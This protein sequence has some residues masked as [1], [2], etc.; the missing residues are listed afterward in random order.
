M[1]GKIKKL[2]LFQIRLGK[3]FI[4][5]SFLELLTQRIPQKREMFLDEYGIEIPNV[6]IL[7]SD[8]L[9]E[10]EYEIRVSG[11]PVQRFSC[12]KSC[13][14]AFVTGKDTHKIKG[15]P[16]KDP[17]FGMDALWISD[18]KI[19]TAKNYGFHAYPHDTIVVTNLEEVIK[20][21][22]KAIITTQY[23]E[24]LLTEAEEENAALVRCIRSKYGNNVLFTVKGVLVSLL[25]ELVSIRD[26]ISILEVISDAASDDSIAT[27]AERTRHVLGHAIVL[28]VCNDGELNII[29][30][31]EETISYLLRHCD[32]EQYSW[33]FKADF[34]SKCSEIITEINNQNTQPAIIVPDEIRKSVWTLIN[35]HIPDITVIS[36]SEI[37]TAINKSQFLKIN[38]LAEISVEKNCMANEA[39]DNF[40]DEKVMK[41]ILQSDALITNKKNGIVV[42]LRYENESMKCP[43]VLLAQKDLKL[44]KLLTETKK[45]CDASCIG[46]PVLENKTLANGLFLDCTEDKPIDDK[47][48]KPVANVYALLNNRNK[49]VI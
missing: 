47:Y 25:E 28:Q 6:N 43:K 29:Q 21:N 44:V 7:E 20:K 38:A 32:N 39:S 22:M 1:G 45:T 19:E 9:G 13:S 30:I 16:T 48:L 33:N 41:K 40:I 8:K 2:P 34:T 46:S 15:K 3:A 24:D 4:N 5:D 23:V 18:S 49:K 12:K 31:S 14:L 27:I 37:K 17:T 10:W 11:V 36:L 26:I 35:P 42:G